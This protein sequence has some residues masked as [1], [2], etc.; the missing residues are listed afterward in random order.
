[1][2]TI[3]KSNSFSK[4]NDLKIATFSFSKF[5]QN[6]DENSRSLN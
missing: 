3:F 6:T 2:I 4:S 5:F 1:M